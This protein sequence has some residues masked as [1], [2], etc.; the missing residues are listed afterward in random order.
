MS[1]IKDYLHEMED[2][3]MRDWISERISDESLDESSDEWQSLA[4]AYT[5]YEAHLSEIEERAFEIEWLQE[6]E[7]NIIHEI[8]SNELDAIKVMA[9]SN[10][11]SKKSIGMILHES[12]FVKMSYAHAVTLLESFLGDTLKSIILEKPEHLINAM[13][14]VKEVADARYSIHD[15]SQTDLNLGSLT[16]KHISEILFHNIPKVINV[17]NVVLGKKIKTDYSK[18]TR[19]TKVRHD[20]VHRNGRK[21]DGTENIISTEDLFQA[22][23]DIKEFSENLQREIYPD[24]VHNFDPF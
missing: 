22:I 8:F 12:T 11:N 24:K 5:E 9:T 10:L 2:E 19:I 14:G 20:I 21:T 7:Q 4:L 23:N 16:L 18:I 15:L 6:N 3:R 1:R 13:K 17:Y